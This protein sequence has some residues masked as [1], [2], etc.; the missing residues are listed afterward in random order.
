MLI[1]IRFWK[2]REMVRQFNENMAKVFSPG[3]ITCLDELMSIW[4]NMFT[5]PG[6]MVVP[7]KPHPFGN[8]WHTICCGISGIMFYLE[9]VEGKDRPPELPDLNRNKFGNTVNLLLRMCSTI[10][11][12]GRI[13]ILDSGFCVL[14]GI[15]ELAKNGV[16]AGAQIKKGSIDQNTYWV[17]LLILTSKMNLLGNQMQFVVRWKVYNTTFLLSMK[18]NTHQKSWE[19]TVQCLSAIIKRR[20]A[21]SNVFQMVQ[22][23]NKSSNT[24]NHLVTISSTDT[25]LM[26]IITYAT[27]NHQ[28][29]EHGVLIHGRTV[30]L[31]SS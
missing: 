31:H 4:T 6:W 25:M 1:I 12:S 8:E 18:V 20:Q 2:I 30:C 24:S 7:C 29:R 11:G 23:K 22:R 16:F 15:V 13:V 19:L 3:W 27:K 9:L 5:C 17:M 14:K 21:K 26:T 10:F 28:L